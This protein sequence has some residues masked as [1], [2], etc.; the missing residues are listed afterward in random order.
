MPVEM[1]S[2]IL[3]ADIWKKLFRIRLWTKKVAENEVN[4]LRKITFTK[5]ITIFLL[6]KR[7]GAYLILQKI[8]GAAFPRGRRLKEGGAFFKVKKT[9]KVKSLSFNTLPLF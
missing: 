3:C 8:F 4:Y 9:K 5:T 2:I 1:D 7:S 6:L